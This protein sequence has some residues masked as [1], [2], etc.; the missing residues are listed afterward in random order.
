MELAALTCVMA[1]V[2]ATC[3]HGEHGEHQVCKFTLTGCLTTPDNLA[4][5]QSSAPC[6]LC[7]V[8]QQLPVL[9]MA[10]PALLCA[11]HPSNSCHL[12]HA[13]AAMSLWIARTKHRIAL[14]VHFACCMRPAVMKWPY[15][16]WL[17]RQRN[18][19]VHPHPPQHA[20]RFLCAGLQLLLVRP[21]DCRAL[22]RAGPFSVTCRL[23]RIGRPCSAVACGYS[24][25]LAAHVGQDGATH[26][27]V[28]GPRPRKGNDP[29]VLLLLLLFQHQNLTR[30]NA[31]QLYV[32]LMHI[33][34]SKRT[35]P[36]PIQNGAK[37]CGRALTRQVRGMGVR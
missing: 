7:T 3:T 17:W 26:G 37:A 24:T 5:F 15:L 10:R 9:L 30:Q 22:C 29:R 20:D 16:P 25:A 28:L 35:A 13:C 2:T 18:S 6:Q 21:L 11:H 23:R 12:T 33:D 34:R 4:S 19:S 14:H 1:K 27:G 8:R 31:L 32:R 36:G